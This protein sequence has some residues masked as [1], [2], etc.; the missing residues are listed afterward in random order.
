MGWDSGIVFNMIFRPLGCGGILGMISLLPSPTSPGPS[1][2]GI[3]WPSSLHSAWIGGLRWRSTCHCQEMNLS[4]GVIRLLSHLPSPV[5]L[6][7]LCNRTEEVLGRW[8]R[9][10]PHSFSVRSRKMVH[11]CAWYTKASGTGKWILIPIPPP[12]S[13]INA[14]PQTA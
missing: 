6:D 9:G 2:P 14:P 4:L 7:K 11:T 13:S 8:G 5:E 12:H 1:S 10:L 3:L